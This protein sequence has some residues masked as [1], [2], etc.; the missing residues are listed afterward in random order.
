M[1]AMRSRHIFRHIR[2]LRAM[3]AGKLVRRG[4]QHLQLQQ[5]LDRSRQRTYTRL[6]H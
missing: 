2:H 4:Q 1:Y 3:P 6:S 5:R